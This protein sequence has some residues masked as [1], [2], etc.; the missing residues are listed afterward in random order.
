MPTLTLN[1]KKRSEVKNQIKKLRLKNQ[2]PAILFGHGF[3]NQNLT[4]EYINFEKIYQQAGGSSLVDLV[5][6][7]GESIKVL[8]QDFQLHPLSNKFIHVDLRQVKMTEKLRTSI[9]LN[10]FGEAPAVKNLGGMLVKNLLEVHVECLPQDLV[11]EIKVD[12]SPL[13]ELGNA[14][15]IKD[16]LA[17]PGIKILAHD[18]DV[19]ASVTAVVVEEETPVAAP[20]VDLSQIKTEGEEKREKKAVEEGDVEEEAKKEKKEAKKE[21][22]K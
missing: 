20:A 6:D 8:I 17:P 3:Q 11:G 16:V 10:F 14:I 1:A 22:K 21:E 9:K 7:G 18:E 12:I 13:K 19:V 2:I 4:L 5:I 15:H